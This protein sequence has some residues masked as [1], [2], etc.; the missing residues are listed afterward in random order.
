MT[1][2]LETTLDTTSQAHDL[3]GFESLLAPAERETLERVRALLGDIDDAEVAAA[4]ET[5]EFP[6][7]LVAPLGGAGFLGQHLAVEDEPSH[8][9]RGLMTAELARK[10]ASL[11][12]FAGV[13]G[14]LFGISVRRFGSEAQKAEILPRVATGEL[15]GAF[16]LTEP[17]SGSD[18]AGGITTT[19]ARDGD[20]WVL[21]GQKRWIGNATWCDRV[22]VWAKEAQGNAGAEGRFL[23]FVVPTDAPGFQAAKIE[24][25]YSLRTVQNAH[26]TLDGVRVSDSARLPG[27]TSFRE[28]SQVLTFTRL[29]V[30]WA[31]VGN[32]LGAFDAALAHARE[33]EQFGRP[34]ARFQLVQDLLVRAEL[35]IASSAGVLAQA[36]RLA[37]E[38]R[39]TEEQASLAKLLAASR[40]R[41]TV[42]LCREVFGGDGILLENKVIK[43][44]MDAEAFYTFEGTHQINTLIVGRALTG[45]SAFV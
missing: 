12:T 41:E 3:M 32:S 10:D 26:I 42:A 18:I 5:A 28:T 33:H 31:A 36:A 7:E 39:L 9:L 21:T 24:G 45:L 35:N 43:H 22:V 13:S 40:A 38:G 37:D 2:H 4:W 11:A 17:S 27:V 15:V 8:L 30:G 25:K 23:G 20:G 14:S 29:E 19:A 44:F 1:A 34:I 6:V 16:A